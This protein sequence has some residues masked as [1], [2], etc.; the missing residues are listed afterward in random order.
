MLI[1]R[2]ALLAGGV[3]AAWASPRLRGQD[4][5]PPFTIEVPDVVLSPGVPTFVAVNTSGYTS[6][7]VALL[8]PFGRVR[9][10]SRKWPTEPDVSNGQAIDALATAG[11]PKSLVRHVARVTMEP[12]RTMTPSMA[13]AVTQIDPASAVGRAVVQVVHSSVSTAPDFLE[14]TK[15]MARLARFVN[16]PASPPGGQFMAALTTD[17][18]V[19]LKIWRGETGRGEPVHQAEF[20]HLP[21]GT[22]PIRW[23]L[24]T[25]RGAAETGRYLGVLVCVPEDRRLKPT[26]LAAYFAVRMP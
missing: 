24:M 14:D 26:N 18:S 1:S 20:K 7:Q 8:D 19:Q 11:D 23:D 9:S 15:Q 21:R 22:H 6:C 4:L 2:R 12:T 13:M 17:S 16:D 5:A 3:V 10:T 25:R